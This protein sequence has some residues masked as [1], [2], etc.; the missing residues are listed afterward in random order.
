M[1]SRLQDELKR[2][3]QLNIITKVDQPT[4]WISSLV[5]NQKPKIAQ[6]NG[7]GENVNGPQNP[8]QPT[9]ETRDTMLPL[10]K[11]RSQRELECT[12]SHPTVA[13]YNLPHLHKII[14]PVSTPSGRL[15]YF[16]QNWKKLTSDQSVLQTV[17]G[18]RI[19]L[20][21]ISGDQGKQEE[22]Q[23]TEPLC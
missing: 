3:E 6:T 9:A 16:L 22:V 7:L 21:S 19:P 4:E 20:R 11:H 17:T 5:I 14:P 8:V 10:P 1:K 2:L 13:D 12:K 18:Y 23:K 15:V